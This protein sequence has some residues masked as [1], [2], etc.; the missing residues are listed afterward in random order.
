MK[1]RSRTLAGKSIH[2]MLA[3]MEV[4]NKPSF[5]YREESFSYIQIQGNETSI[6]QTG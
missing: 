3:G 6:T 4:Y 5:A 2:A 1:S